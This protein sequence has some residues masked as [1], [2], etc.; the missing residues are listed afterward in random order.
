MAQ[1]AQ[2]LQCTTLIRQRQRTTHHKTHT[3]IATKT[4][5][6]HHRRANTKNDKC[7]S[8][9]TI[10]DREPCK[11]ISRCHTHEVPPPTPKTSPKKR[12]TFG[13]PGIS[14]RSRKPGTS[15]PTFTYAPM[16]VTRSTYPHSSAPRDTSLT[17]IG[18]RGGG[19]GKSPSRGP[20]WWWWRGGE[21][22]T[23]GKTSVTHNIEICSILH[24]NPGLPRETTMTSTS[25]GHGRMCLTSISF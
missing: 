12:P 24:Q 25:V 17:D 19:S 9:R 20:S 13:L 15:A 3:H 8:I 6:Q 11:M 1:T 21:G 10:D 22:G 7:T 2:N 16:F 23:Q 18:G 4:R 14:F 5:H